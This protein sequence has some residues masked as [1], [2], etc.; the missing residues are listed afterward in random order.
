MGGRG[1]GN[2]EK[3]PRVPSPQATPFRQTT[4][5]SSI[6]QPKQ[7][8]LAAG[9]TAMSPNNVD[10]KN[11]GLCNKDSGSRFWVECDACNLWFHSLCAGFSPEENKTLKSPQLQYVC[12]NCKK[13]P[14]P[15]ITSDQ[16]SQLLNKM[17]SLATQVA[18]LQ[19]DMVGKF[20][21]LTDD[22]AQI[23]Q[24]VSEVKT[25]IS[26]IDDRLKDVE[27]S[28]QFKSSNDFQSAVSNVFKTQSA[29]IG[30]EVMDRVERVNNIMINGS[31]N[32]LDKDEIL[33]LASVVGI[34]D[35]VVTDI[36][37]VSCW[38]STKA[39]SM[40]GGLP[41]PPKQMIKVTFK[42]KSFKTKFCS[43]N[44]RDKVNALVDGHK[45]KNLYFRWDKTPAQQKEDKALWDLANQKNLL[46]SEADKMKIKWFPNP[47]TGTLV[48]KDLGPV[49]GSV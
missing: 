5:G 27:N 14:V 44:T 46:L 21:T 28:V 36:V 39:P 48:R 31:T 49:P 20:D 35:L 6:H 10:N 38:P 19:N 2:K 11:C 16:F 33:E 45:F 7:L 30:K 15:K 23:K 17:D 4:P 1:R 47:R 22:V 43:K 42:N 18:T 32:P 41:A 13:S 40:T 25:E 3:N 24:S 9:A 12:K 37:G 34:D 8:D 26:T 29:D